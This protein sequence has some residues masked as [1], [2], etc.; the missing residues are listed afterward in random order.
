VTDLFSFN[1]VGTIADTRHG[2]TGFG[3]DP[4]GNLLGVIDAKNQ[5]TAYT[6]DSMDRLG[7]RTDALNRA[8]GYQYDL[9]GNLNVFTD[10]KNQAAGFTYDGLNRRTGASYADGSATTFTY[11]AVGRLARVSDAVAGTIEFGYDTLS[12][13]TLET[14]PFGSLQYTYD[15][16]GRR[17]A[18]TVS[19]QQPVTY[20]YDA[21]S[22][23]IQVAQG[24]LVVG[25]G[26]D[27]A[28]RRTRLTYPNGTSTSY[29]YDAASR[30]TTIL[31][32]G[33]VGVLESATY[34]YDAAGNRLSVTRASRSA[35]QLPAAVTA[36]Y[37]A[38]NEQLAFGNATLQYDANG[39]LVNDG[40]LT[41]TWD[42]R[43]RLIARSGLGI[44][45]GFVYDALG[46]RVSK[47][48]NGVTT[49]FLY[50]GNDVI[51]EMQ[52]GAVTAFYLRG[53]N[54]D[55]PFI[56]ITATGNEYYHTDA[57][58]SVLALTDQ[59]GTVQTTYTYEP[60]GAATMTGTPSANPFQYT[61][62][63]NDGTGL[64]YYRA[65]YYRPSAGQFISED[66]IGFA[67]G[68][69]NFY[70]Y[71]SNNPILLADPFGLTTSIVVVSDYGIGTHAAVRIDN[72]RNA[73]L[74]DPGGSYASTEPR[75]SG[76]TF[77]AQAANLDR[78]IKYHE[79]VGSTVKVYDFDTSPEVEAKIAQKI[80]ELGGV[81]GGLCSRAV[82]SV[83][84]GEGP[85]KDLRSTLFPGRLA[86]QL[87]RILKEE[88]RRKDLSPCLSIGGRKPHSC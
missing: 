81:T 66:P 11:D 60:F 12:R 40:A 51:A 65:R 76:D 10:R 32:Q 62:R 14:T 44:S 67:S 24:S 47:T 35:T 74:Y 61:G 26:Y 85:F 88:Q 28:G 69:L 8:E 70:A 77:S 84:G 29:T 79:N 86:K 43:N 37:D 87:E 83:I 4:N 21:A 39:N 30:L 82:C 48:I 63:E 27:A 38:A 22:R 68:D 73:L 71:A 23:L 59:T 49:Q 6:Y 36:A 54:I 75:G 18:M 25:I 34:T 16:L 57:L 46:R 80:D 72:G 5:A 56:R 50:D 53:L 3:D 64:Y 19:G 7:T 41:H 42:A 20:Q 13:L 15:A 1:R 78:Y 55:E 45:E 33:P 58:G 52:G 9:N 17:I 2:L 31:H